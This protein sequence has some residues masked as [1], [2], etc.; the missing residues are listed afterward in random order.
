MREEMRLWRQILLGLE[1]GGVASYED[2]DEVF[3]RCG[4][5]RRTYGGRV[6]QRIR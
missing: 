4:G 2:V 5:N 1:N 6:C 3:L